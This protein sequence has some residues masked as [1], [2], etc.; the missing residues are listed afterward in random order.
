MSTYTDNL[1][2]I[3]NN[4]KEEGWDMRASAIEHAAARMDS[5][6]ILIVNLMV[7]ESLVKKSKEPRRQKS[8]DPGKV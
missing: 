1:R 7:G 2:N 8:K 5:M 3:A 6:E 4:L